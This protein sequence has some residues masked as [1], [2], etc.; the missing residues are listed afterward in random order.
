MCSTGCYNM[1]TDALANLS[2]KTVSPLLCRLGRN[3]AECY[4]VRLAMATIEV[5]GR[6]K[7]ENLPQNVQQLV[8]LGDFQLI[9]G[10]A[11]HNGCKLTHHHVDLC[12]GN[13][14]HVGNGVCVIFNP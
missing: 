14:G 6:P 13:I 10:L 9:A 7:L 2:L 11:M 8:K 5:V 12:W 4:V 3:L 1:I